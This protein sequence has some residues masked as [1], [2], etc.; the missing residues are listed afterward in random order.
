MIL[1]NHKRDITIATLQRLINELRAGTIT[2]LHLRAETEVGV[3]AINIAG[4]G[5]YWEVTDNL[6][7]PTILPF[8][9]QG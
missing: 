4:G 8:T 9:K 5:E 3:A 1:S 2:E 6:E 7:G